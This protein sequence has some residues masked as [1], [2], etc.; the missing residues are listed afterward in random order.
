MISAN[1]AQGFHR[2]ND[3]KYNF[4]YSI[5]IVK[6]REMSLGSLINHHLAPHFRLYISQ[7]KIGGWLGDWFS[8]EK[9]ITRSGGKAKYCS[10]NSCIHSVVLPPARVVVVVVVSECLP[11]ANIYLTNIIMKVKDE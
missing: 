1:T 9:S 5:I 7:S 10:S 3:R 11:N 6:E 8:L 4:L 2:R